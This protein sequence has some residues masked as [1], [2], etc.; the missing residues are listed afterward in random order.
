MD[1]NRK[2]KDVNAGIHHASSIHHRRSLPQEAS[3]GASLIFN[4]QWNDYKFSFVGM[5]MQLVH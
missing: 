4:I 3:T 2:I 5:T 1:D